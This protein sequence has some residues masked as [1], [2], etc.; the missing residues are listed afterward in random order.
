[1]ILIARRVF[2][3]F[4]FGIV[5]LD[6]CLGPGVLIFTLIVTTVVSQYIYTCKFPKTPGFAFQNTIQFLPAVFTCPGTLSQ[7][8]KKISTNPQ[9]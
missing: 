7:S 2:W 3:C 1:M 6:A 8:H 9:P 5:S 4:P